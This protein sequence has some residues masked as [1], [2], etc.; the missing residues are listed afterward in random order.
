[1]KPLYDWSTLRP[2]YRQIEA[3]ERQLLLRDLG[4]VLFLVALAFVFS[5]SLVVIPTMPALGGVLFFGSIMGL[6][7]FVAVFGGH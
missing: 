4:S 2:N 5:A 3:L 1:M 6:I 7:A